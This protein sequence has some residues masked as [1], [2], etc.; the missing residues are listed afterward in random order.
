MYPA[1]PPGNRRRFGPAATHNLALARLG[2]APFGVGDNVHVEGDLIGGEFRFDCQLR[3][4]TVQR[5]NA[6]AFMRSVGLPLDPGARP[7]GRPALQGESRS[8]PGSA[9]SPEA[10]ANGKRLGH[11]LT[12][13]QRAV[14]ARRDLDARCSR[15]RLD[16]GVR[17]AGE[18]R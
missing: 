11:A 18:G 5:W 6:L 8:G 14:R 9:T 10:A 3:E 17:G 4:G 7:A 2:D 13:E 1:A 16:R 12:A 15:D